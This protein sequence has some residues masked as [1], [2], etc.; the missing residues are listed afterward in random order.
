MDSAAPNTNFTIGVNAGDTSNKYGLKS[1]P[2]GHCS[3]A[4][5]TN[6]SKGSAPKKYVTRLQMEAKLKKSSVAGQSK[7]VKGVPKGY[8][9]RAD[10]IVKLEQRR[11]CNF[12]ETKH[13]TKD[14][15]NIQKNSVQIECTSQK[16]FYET[17]TRIHKSDSSQN[18]KPLSHV[19]LK[20]N[21]TNDINDHIAFLNRQY[22]HRSEHFT[23]NK[24][25]TDTERHGLK[26]TMAQGLVDCFGTRKKTTV[27]PKDSG[28]TEKMTIHTQVSEINTGQDIRINKSIANLCIIS[29]N[30]NGINDD[31]EECPN[32]RRK[33][34][35]DLVQKYMCLILSYSRNLRGKVSQERY[36]TPHLYPMTMFILVTR[37][38]VFC[39]TKHAC[40]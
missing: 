2:V 39:M 6:T 14:K 36:G 12:K 9:S 7:S 1:E 34:I 30:A 22:V 16:P 40:Q 4:R 3:I 11:N 37:K 8:V 10:M 32:R 26:A 35:S 29:M 31:I 19:K 33:V 25:P 27:V 28:M 17:R 18:T 15:P 38:P 13:S 5:K 20:H 23:Q 24:L 21:V